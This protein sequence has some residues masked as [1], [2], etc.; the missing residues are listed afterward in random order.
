MPA[1]TSSALTSA[2]SV[3]LTKPLADNVCLVQASGTY[4]TVTFVVEGSID[5]TNY[6]ALSAWRYD[7]NALAT[8][9]I[10]PS[11]NAEQVWR[12]PC[13]GLAYVRARATAVGSG[14]VTFTLASYAAVG[15]PLQPSF[16][17][18][19]FGATTVS[20]LTLTGK[21][22]YTDIGTVA[23][24]GTNQAGATAI[25]THITYVSGADDA[26]GVVLPTAVAGI[27][28]QIY[29][30]HATSGLKVYP[31]TSDDINDGSANAAVTI[32]GK[33]LAVFRAL[34][35]TTWAAMYTANT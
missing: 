13:D 17:S 25:T 27:E 19:T 35:A 18:M 31:N 22:A 29:N 20:D 33:T 32:E 7:T 34:D 24:A 2:G 23:A 15:L 8:G 30:T 11:D 26:A 12:V 28:R 9:T 4:G 16:S 6:F 3:T 21:P 14:T 5:G 1:S 10:A